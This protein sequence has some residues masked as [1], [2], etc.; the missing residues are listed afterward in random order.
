MKISADRGA[1]PEVLDIRSIYGK[2]VFKLA[3]PYPVTNCKDKGGDCSLHI[4]EMKTTEGSQGRE[5]AAGHSRGTMAAP[6]SRV[7]STDTA[8]LLGSSTGTGTGPGL[9]LRS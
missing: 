7:R 5:E 9:G 4:C 6:R 1:V 3:N 2:C 8:G